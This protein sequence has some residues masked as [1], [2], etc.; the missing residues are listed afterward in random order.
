MQ[1]VQKSGTNIITFWIKQTSISKAINYDSLQG[2][3]K[4]SDLWFTARPTVQTNSTKCVLKC[5]LI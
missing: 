2:S 4:L 3:Y 5:V 1:I